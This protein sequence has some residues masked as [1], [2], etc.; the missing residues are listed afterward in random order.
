[1]NISIRKFE[2]RGWRNQSSSLVRTTHIGGVYIC[3]YQ[4]DLQGG[5]TLDISCSIFSMAPA[6]SDWGLYPFA[7]NKWRKCAGKVHIRCIDDLGTRYLRDIRFCTLNLNRC[8]YC[9]L[10]FFVWYFHVNIELTLYSFPG[11][12][13]LQIWRYKKKFNDVPAFGKTKVSQREEPKRYMTAKE[14]SLQL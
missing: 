10:L 6:T 9:P 7:V 11:R 14:E 3:L 12:T 5:T 1:M 4:I 2:L 8:I 13:L